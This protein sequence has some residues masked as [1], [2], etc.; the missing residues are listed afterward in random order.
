MLFQVWF[1]LA[2]FSRFRFFIVSVAMF[3]HLGI[4]ISMGLLTFS[5]IMAGADCSIL[6]G[7]TRSVSRQLYVVCA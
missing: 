3:F 7:A 1:P 6:N 2:V 5:L 4:A